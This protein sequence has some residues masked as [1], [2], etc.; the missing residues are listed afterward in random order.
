MSIPIL[1]KSK[2]SNLKQYIPPLI[3]SVSCKGLLLHC[4]HFKIKNKEKIVVNSDE[5]LTR[6]KNCFNF[7]LKNTYFQN[8]A[9]LKR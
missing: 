7:K 5:I 9:K 6:K 8:T 3:K 4:K 2:T 1:N